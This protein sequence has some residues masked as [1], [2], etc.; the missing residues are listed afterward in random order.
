MTQIFELKQAKCG[1]RYRAGRCGSS[2]LTL[3]H[4]HGVGNHWPRYCAVAASLKPPLLLKR[5]GLPGTPGSYCTAAAMATVSRSY[6]LC[7]AW[8][9]GAVSASC[10][11]SRDTANRGGEGDGVVM[12]RSMHGVT[13]REYSL[14]TVISWKHSSSA[15]NF[16]YADAANVGWS[17]L[18]PVWKHRKWCQFRNTFWIL[19]PC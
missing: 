5:C 16:V 2:P 17:S 12:W 1:A 19:K 11:C 3:L 10:L 18:P 13:Y 6:S 8:P 14:S 15:A 9:S 4:H 7:L